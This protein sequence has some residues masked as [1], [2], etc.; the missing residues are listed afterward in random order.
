[1]EGKD[2]GAKQAMFE[3]TLVIC[4]EL[5]IPAVNG[6]MVYSNQIIKSMAAISKKVVVIGMAQNEHQ[7]TGCSLQFEEYPENTF[8]NVHARCINGLASIILSGLPVIV[9][10]FE[11]GE[12]QE[13][14]ERALGSKPDSILFSSFMSISFLNSIVKYK[15]S[16]DPFVIYCSHN[17]EYLTKMSVAKQ[18][19]T[20]FLSKIA[21]AIDARRIAKLEKKVFK[22]VDLLTCISEEDKGKY[23]KYF[24]V[25][26][27]VFCPAGYDGNVKEKRL[28]RSDDPRVICLVGSFMWS[29][30]QNNL[31]SFLRHGYSMFMDHDIQVCVV[32]NMTDEFKKKMQKDWSRVLFTGRV[33][34]VQPFLDKAVIGVVPEEAG[35]GFKLKT[36]EY[37]YNRIPL[38]ALKKSICNLNLKH[39]SSAMLFPDMQGLCE[40][41]VDNIRD[42]GL[43]NR[44]QNSAFLS[45]QNFSGI[46]P[47]MTALKNGIDAARNHTD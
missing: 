9:S 46:K 27:S 33:E 31:I 1:M 15:R 36:L 12:R 19:E 47:M 34:S 23:D 3:N 10:R 32:G 43:L 40:G 37:I 24:H 2:R 5:P 38:F 25:K 11:T 6:G 4:R 26:M 41:I 13:F 22:I 42:V 28:I 16:Y 8:F 45:C 39:G 30:K 21:H 17:Y 20:K 18:R 44:L 35:G 29:A 7:E 14:I